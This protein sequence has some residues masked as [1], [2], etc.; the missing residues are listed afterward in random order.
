[1][2]SG[3]VTGCSDP[4]DTGMPVTRHS[5]SKPRLLRQTC[6]TGTFP[7]VERD[8][9]Q[10]G[11]IAGQQVHQRHR[12]IDAGVDIGE[13]GQRTARLASAPLVTSTR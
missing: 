10:F 8:A 2:R 6:C 12:V 7:A 11:V 13:D 3:V 4:F 9:D 1:M 5:S